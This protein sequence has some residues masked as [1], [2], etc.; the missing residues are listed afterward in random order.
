MEC[1]LDIAEPALHLDD[2]E[3]PRRRVERD[4]VAAAAVTE[5]VEA[6]LGPRHPSRG[7][8]PPGRRLLE[9]SVDA[10][11]QPIEVGATPAQIDHQGGIERPGQ[12]LERSNGHALEMMRL[13]ARDDV[14]REVGARAKVRL[15]PSAARSQGSHGGRNVRV[16]RR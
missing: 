1:L 7:A 2:Q 4:K 5:V 6:H 12:A 11:H 13:D 14:P 10:I 9:R 8:E 15:T 16:H 3:G